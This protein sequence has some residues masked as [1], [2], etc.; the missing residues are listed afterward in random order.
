MVHAPTVIWE[1]IDRKE[2]L[3]ATRA[4]LRAKAVASTVTSVEATTEVS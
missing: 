1:H 3:Q 2:L 4:Y